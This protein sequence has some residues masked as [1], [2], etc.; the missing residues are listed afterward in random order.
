MLKAG[1]NY[2]TIW[3]SERLGIYIHMPSK[4][5][6]MRKSCITVGDLGIWRCGNLGFEKCREFSEAH[7]A[8]S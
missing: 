5:L 6:C 2:D 4:R 8:L 3:R 7:G 1:R